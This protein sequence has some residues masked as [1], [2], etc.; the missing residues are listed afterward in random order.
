VFDGG[1]VLA[2]LFFG[3]KGL[4][5]G[6]IAESANFFGI[7]G[8]IF[9]ASHVAKAIASGLKNIFATVDIAILEAVVFFT[10][11]GIFIFI[12][13]IVI[14]YFQDKIVTQPERVIGYLVATVK[15]FLIFSIF[16]AVLSST[17]S[18]KK[19]V[20]SIVLDSKLYS[21]MVEIGKFFLNRE[22]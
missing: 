9:V 4:L 2:S 21:Y 17:P 13:K 7:L 10:I 5:A 6:V 12:S 11:F 1:V 18:L 16:I 14:D 22:K 3:L 20:D 8:G 19:R 15:Y